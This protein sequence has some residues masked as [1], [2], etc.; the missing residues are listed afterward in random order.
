MQDIGRKLLQSVGLP[1][2]TDA[3]IA[4]AIELNDI[5]VAKLERIRAE[6]EGVIID[7]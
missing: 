7:Q 3:D 2:P 6:A 1:N 5:F 4:A